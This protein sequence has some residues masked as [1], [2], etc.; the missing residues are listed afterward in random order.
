MQS[1]V[2]KDSSGR[3]VCSD[4]TIGF[5]SSK[6]VSRGFDRQEG[7]EVAWCKVPAVMVNSVPNSRALQEVHMLSEISHPNIVR[8]IASWVDPS[9]RDLIMIT[10]LYGA[11]LDTYVRKHGKQEIAVIRKWARQLIEALSFLHVRPSPIAHRDIK[12][13]NF[14]INNYTGDVALGDLGF[15]SVLS[16]SRTSNSVL[17]TAEYMS[18]ECLQGQYTHKADVYSF[19]LAL[20]EMYTLKKPYSRFRTI[21]HL[22]MEILNFSPPDELLFVKHAKLK[23]LISDCIKPEA[24]RPCIQDLLQYDFFLSDEGDFALVEDV[25]RAPA[26]F[27]RYKNA[28]ER[29]CFSGSSD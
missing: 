3:F 15:A 2:K 8:M 25:V 9:S 16:E 7:C 4:E 12:C 23:L 22:Y 27:G 14:F 11:P 26:N 19:G 5:G 17:G 21:S 10:N 28:I 29:Y 18:P 6:P 13:A 20:I 1:V 24:T